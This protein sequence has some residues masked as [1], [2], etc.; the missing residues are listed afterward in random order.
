MILTGAKAAQ[1]LATTALALPTVLHLRRFGRLPLQIRDGI[2]PAAGQR[3]DVIPD[4]TGAGAG[5]AARRGARVL[6]LEKRH[7][8][9]PLTVGQLAEAAPQFSR[10]SGAEIA[11]R[12]CAAPPARLRMSSRS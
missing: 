12:E 7:L 5:P 4:V 6:P 3:H 10:T 1:R 11:N 9:T 8:D 2:G